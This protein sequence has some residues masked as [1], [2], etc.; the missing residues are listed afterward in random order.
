MTG[1][2][3]RDLQRLENLSVLLSDARLA[4]LSAAL[5]ERDR[6]CALIEGL[7]DAPPV[8]G[9][10]PAAALRNAA[11][12]AVWTERRRA[13]LE[14]QLSTIE[15]KVAERRAEATLAYGRTLALR[16]LRARSNVRPRYETPD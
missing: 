14:T 3:K 5:A 8:E 9:I 1:N 4:R 6:V 7:T 12:Y 10:D 2:R 13:T 11:L 15:K 16:E